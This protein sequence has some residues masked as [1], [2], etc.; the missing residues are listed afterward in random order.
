MYT[1]TKERVQ[2]MDETLGIIKHTLEGSVEDYNKKHKKPINPRIEEGKDVSGFSLS[3]RSYGIDRGV[4]VYV[5]SPWRPSLG[6]SVKRYASRRDF[7]EDFGQVDF[8]VFRSPSESIL[9]FPVEEPHL[10]RAVDRA[11]L[12]IAR[13]KFKDLKLEHVDPRWV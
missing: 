8:W 10:K 12:E 6:I 9:K 1:L 11:I 4:A 2:E 5:I 7:G 13:I 3:W